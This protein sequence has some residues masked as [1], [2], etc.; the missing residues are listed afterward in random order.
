MLQNML[1]KGCLRTSFQA[2]PR[3]L[4]F[5]SGPTTWAFEIGG[6][7][8]SWRF[9]EALSRDATVFAIFITNTEETI[10]PTAS[11]R[12]HFAR[13]KS[14]RKKLMLCQLLVDSPATGT[15][16]RHAPLVLIARVAMHS[17]EDFLSSAH[18][19][20]RILYRGE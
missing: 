18:A 10:Q 20:A 13:V 4:S 16:H 5:Y 17:R 12:L 1:S 6:E 14:N 2:N 11:K 8:S 15:T 19:T 7:P 9:E 3:L